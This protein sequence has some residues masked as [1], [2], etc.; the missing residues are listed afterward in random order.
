M[1]TEN[2]SDAFC[3]ELLDQ[4]PPAASRAEFTAAFAAALRRFE[5][6]G[7][8]AGGRQAE[9]LL[10]A[11]GVWSPPFMRG[12]RSENRSAPISYAATNIRR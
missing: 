8:N 12:S 3:L 9:S 11:L 5:L 6:A 7:A 4:P 2:L 10:S 1:H